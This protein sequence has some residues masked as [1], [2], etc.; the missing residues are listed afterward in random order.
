MKLYESE[1]SFETNRFLVQE[2][3]SHRLDEE[4]KKGS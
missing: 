2:F 4:L 1:T 3:T